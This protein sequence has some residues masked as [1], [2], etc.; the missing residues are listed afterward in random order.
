M[1]FSTLRKSISYKGLKTKCSGKYTDKKENKVSEKFQYTDPPP[2]N[3]K[4]GLSLKQATEI[5]RVVKR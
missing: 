1:E 5:H 3:K 4:K 2:P